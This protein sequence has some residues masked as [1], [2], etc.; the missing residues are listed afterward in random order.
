M[1]LLYR[2]M[3][4]RIFG[5]LFITITFVLSMLIFRE[6]CSLSADILFISRCSASGLSAIM[7]VSSADADY[8]I[9]F[10]LFETTFFFC[11]NAASENPVMSV[12]QLILIT[13]SNNH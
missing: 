13:P 4:L 10:S 9:K 12:P 1:G 2:R 8:S 6:S 5:V 3:L 7:T 11:C